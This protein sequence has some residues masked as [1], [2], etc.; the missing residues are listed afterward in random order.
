MVFSSCLL[1]ED[2]LSQTFGLSSLTWR[3]NT[4]T[5]TVTVVSSTRASAKLCWN[6][7]SLSTSWRGKK[8]ARISTNADHN[9][10]M[11]MKEVQKDSLRCILKTRIN[12]DVYSNSNTGL[13]YN[14]TV[15][16]QVDKLLW[17]DCISEW[18]YCHLHVTAY[19]FNKYNVQNIHLDQVH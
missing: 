4:H 7:S 11:K 3:S 12:T 6:C 1:S 2:F 8:T 5:F 9:T 18:N 10:A 17:I 15:F 14:P 19:T 13:V 16:T